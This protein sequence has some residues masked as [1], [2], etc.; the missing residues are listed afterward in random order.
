MYQELSSSTFLGI[1][2]F[3]IKVEVHISNGLPTFNIVGLGDAAVKESKERV[4]CAIVNSG[5][6]FPPGKIIVNLSPGNIKKIGTHFDVAIAASIL[7]ASSQ[8]SIDPKDKIFIGELSLSGEV[9]PVKGI[10]PMVIEALQENIDN[11]IL[12]LDNLR[13]CSI[14]ND[15]NFYPVKHLKD[16]KNGLKKIHLK[17]FDEKTEQRYDI[18]ISSIIGHEFAKRGLEI[19]AAGKHPLLLIGSPGSGK[20]MLARSICSILPD[21][22]REEAIEVS[23]IYS[24]MGLSRDNNRLLL[25]PP[26]RDPHHT[27]TPIAMSGGGNSLNPGEISLAHNGVLFLDEILEFKKPAIE[28]LRQPIEDSKIKISKSYGTLEYPSN[29]HLIAALNPCSCGYFG[30][31]IKKCTCTENEI[32]NYLRKLSGPII[33]RFDMSIS[34]SSISFNEIKNRKN[35]KATNEIKERVINA[36]ERQKSRY[37]KLKIKYNNQLTGDHLYEYCKLDSDSEEFLGSLYK[38]FGFSLRSF[39][40]II[41]V[42][43]TISDLNGEEYITK[44]HITE[45]LNYK[46]TI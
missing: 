45:A 31:N 12:P 35:K 41:K 38:D 3:I 16:F 22:T 4:R 29:F 15:I 43:R 44:K 14:L 23:K 27:T 8:I 34:V 26:F 46:V 37:K 2:G 42:S 18:D 28:V 7:L 36:R 9:R 25:S 10:L 5:F 21:L 39:N 13:E 32:K 1:N 11:I 20:T 40:N 19:A 6:D 30:S 17:Q 33:D 24:I